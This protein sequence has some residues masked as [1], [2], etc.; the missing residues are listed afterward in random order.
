M[1]P[2]DKYILSDNALTAT[3]TGFTLQL[4]S[5][6]YRSLPL[7]CMNIKAKVDGNLID[8]NNITIEV[9]GKSYAFREMPE[10]YKEWL[11]IQD[12]ATLKVATAT[13]LE[14]GRKYEVQVDFRLYIPYILAGPEATPLLAISSVTKNL[15]CQ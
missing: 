14:K 10:L 9:N 13:P 12:A 3:P 8:E 1:G 5:H 4:R 2:L 11:F 7:S 6:W 15:T